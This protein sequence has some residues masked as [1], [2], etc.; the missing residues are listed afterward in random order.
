MKNKFTSLFAAVLFVFCAASIS[1]ISAQV[2][3]YRVTDRQLQ[4][5]LTRID[6]RTENFRRT[7]DNSFNTG[8]LDGTRSE[9]SISGY[10]T[11]FDNSVDQLRQNI[12][13]QNSSTADVE[14]VLNQATYIDSFVRDYRLATNSLNQW[15]LIRTDLTT[16][17]GYYNVRWNWNR[18][19]GS[20]NNSGNS[21]DSR[22][23]GTYRLNVGQSDDVRAVLDRTL[24]N[25]T[26]NSTQTQSGNRGRNLE[27]RLSSPDTLA[28]EKRGNAVTIASSLQPQVTFQADGVARTETTPN[29]RTI[30]ITASS[31][32]NG[33]A[34]SYEGDR[35]NDF[36]VN[37]VP[38]GNGQLRVV[39]RL[40]LENRNETITVASVYDK[41]NNVAEWSTV[42]NNS[43]SG[44]GTGTPNSGNYSDFIV[45]NSTRLTAVLR[46]AI[47]T[48][49]SQNNDRFTLEVTSPSQYSGAIIEGRI[50]TAE[51]SGRVSGRASVS[52][53]FDSIRLRNGQTHRFAGFIESVRAA[54]GDNVTVNNEGTVRD[55]NQTTKTVTRAGIGAAL[56]A[57]IGAIAGGGQGAAIG[58][59]AGAGA[60]AGT[61]LVQGRDNIDLGQGSEFT[62]TASSPNNVNTNR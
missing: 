57:I 21:F 19:G 20:G 60:G 49:D 46:N 53:E 8:V 43:N 14:N 6:T 25:S 4:N 35:A 62:I 13:G 47:N 16:L 28:I 48:R 1:N 39:R 23:S 5:L 22:L 9:E 34:L 11:E 38:S 18:P 17:A 2:R 42:N 56:G 10:I 37:F 33:V 44:A 61:V 7:V 15:N 3:P 45:P 32:Y 51:K 41:V 26:G 30:K 52:M 59:T 29:G 27:R 58:A 24:N 36:Y 54:N 12:D 55:G 31:N 50:A 40:Y